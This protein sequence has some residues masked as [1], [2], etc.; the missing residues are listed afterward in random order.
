MGFKSRQ[1]ETMGPFSSL[2]R[3][4]GNVLHNGVGDPFIQGWYLLGLPKSQI[5]GEGKVYPPF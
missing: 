3:I 2:F 1:T 5:R 4:V